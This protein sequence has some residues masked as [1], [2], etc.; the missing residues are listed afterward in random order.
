MMRWK[1]EKCLE[2]KRWLISWNE[3]VLAPFFT[4]F[5]S[6]FFNFSSLFSSSTPISHSPF[7]LLFLFI[8]ISLTM[9]IGADKWQKNQKKTTKKVNI[10]LVAE[11]I[12][13]G[14]MRF[15]GRK[16]VGGSVFCFFTVQFE[17]RQ[18]T[19]MVGGSRSK[20]TR[21]HGKL[22]WR[23]KKR[24]ELKKNHGQNQN[25]K[26]NYQ[27]SWEKEENHCESEFEHGKSGEWEK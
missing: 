23:V 15:L 11:V 8:S 2:G 24:V 14:K 12:R 16:W 3:P 22:G 7:L 20:I 13:N 25:I 27:K 19:I 10:E 17:V 6:N 4:N 26:Q 18:K 5:Y 21:N 9:I 1:N